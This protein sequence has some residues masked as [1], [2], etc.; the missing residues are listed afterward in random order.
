MPI[1][2][3]KI[4]TIILA[5]GVGKRM[6]SKIPK[7]L[8]RI[9]GRRIVSFVIELAREIGSEQT[10][11]VVNERSEDFFESL[12]PSVCYAIQE[13]P[14]GTG[15]AAMKGL[16]KVTHDKV[17][18]LCGDVPLL[19]T[20][21]I[22]QLIE[23]HASQNA[24]MTFLTCQLSDPFG[25]GRVLRDQNGRVMKIVEQTDATPE[26]Q[27]IQEINAGVYYANTKMISS[28]LKN[29]TTDNE[30]GE[31]YLTDAIH[32]IVDSGKTVSGYMIK[33]KEEITGINTKEQLAQ[34]RERVKSEW[35]GLLMKRG[36]YI[37]D[38]AT[39]NIDLSVKIGD[40][41]H[42][43]PYSFIEGNTTIADGETVGPFVWI[44]D[45]KVIYSTDA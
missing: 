11:L 16:E 10:I 5:A 13:K 3:E 23:Y 2:H 39:T 19:R 45:G 9:L 29:V 32:K 20:N 25:Y 41:V 28:A 14:L 44:R 7:I 4:S 17:L 33:N 18:I 42:I 40:G 24:D 1:L 43:R 22:L 6:K 35:F 37:E 34:V 26:Q 8:H 15:D 21:T 27:K 30:Q 36:V 38:P 31:Y 12:D